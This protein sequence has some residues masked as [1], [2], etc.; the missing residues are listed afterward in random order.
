MS[1]MAIK[2]DNE[3]F[4]REK[5]IELGQYFEILWR[6]KWRIVIF[7]TLVASLVVITLYNTPPYY[8]SKGRLLI[9]SD[10]AKAVSIDD[11][12]GLDSSRKEY[13]QTQFEII[14]SRRLVERAIE[15]L[16]LVVHPEFVKPKYGKWQAWLLSTV[17]TAPN[18][19]PM[20][21]VRGNLSH[22]LDWL[23][24]DWSS[25]PTDPAAELA[26]QHTLL[27]QEF[28]SRLVVAPVP[29]TQLVDIGFY[30]K[31][32][33]LA[34]LVA[35]TMG[36]IYI[37]NHL[38]AKLNVTR[39]ASEWLSARLDELLVGLRI[40]EEKLQLFREANGLLEI[41]GT[42]GL[43]SVEMNE[44][45]SQLSLA[46]QRRD[47]ANALLSLVRRKGAGSI[48]DLDGLAEISGHRFIQEMQKSEV[49]AASSVAELSKRY[50]PKHNKMI[51]AKAQLAEVRANMRSQVRKLV[52]GI[53]QEYQTLNSSAAALERQ[54]NKAKTQYQ[55]QSR[56]EVEYREIQR[57]V[58]SNRRIYE[59]FLNR[60]KET[61]AV[62]DFNAAHARFTDMAEP[63]LYPAK[64]KKKL[65]LVLATAI[66]AVFAC[67]IALIH[68]A[69][70]DTITTTDQVENKLASK[71]LGTIPLQKSKGRLDANHFFD[72]TAA[73]F[74][75]SWRT[76]RTSY[77]LAHLDDG[78]KRIC[79]TST[80]PGEGKSTSSF[81]FALALSQLERVLLIEADLRKPVLAG[82]L[83][84]PSYQ[85]GLSNLISG[86]H[87]KADSIYTVPDTSLDVMVAGTPVS[88]PLELL[89]SKEFKQLLER[90]PEHYDRVIVDTAPVDVVSDALV[91]S[92]LVDSVIYLVK[93]GKARRSL[94]KRSLA[95]LFAVHAKV[96]GVVLN[97]VPKNNQTYKRY[98]SYY[99]TGKSS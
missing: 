82:A 87:N 68:S 76:V 56:V 52:Q 51:A 4:S 98:K 27:V 57:E 32:P 72:N 10:Q 58:E 61:G 64:P 63:S 65:I 67:A 59:T 34:A 19:D 71:L 53:E 44:L 89:E 3:L 50:G 62:A 78:A 88:N 23:P 77:L 37:E 83:N 31:S 96:D 80:V 21:V 70:T 6:Y 25:Q 60:M 90:L 47:D 40:S 17:E 8:L 33:E 95:R 12:Y 85:P 26:Y 15:R 30:A 99:G 66:A 92:R 18:Q 39:K 91:V 38:D 73:S 75:E 24:I 41:D 49:D 36:D 55:E 11:F 48:E 69:I 16:N 1:N 5:D 13:L 84:L 7:V 74:A 20:E 9:E 45:T 35:N 43:V 79:I 28:S 94:I 2:M 42:V 86:T 22:Y 14:K 54:L 29:N 46:R 93:F 81:N 97:A